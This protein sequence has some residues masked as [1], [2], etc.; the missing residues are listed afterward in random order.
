MDLYV[1]NPDADLAL[2]DGGANYLPPA[3]VRQMARDLAL[4]PAWYASPGSAVLAPSAYNDVFL[5]QM[6]AH[7]GLD[8]RLLTEPE[9]SE[10]AVERV[11]PWGWNAAVCRRLH[12]AGVPVDVLPGAD[13]L[14]RWRMLASRRRVGEWLEAF[15]ELPFCVG[16]SR[17]LYTLD[18][19]RAYAEGGGE[20]VLKMPWSGS[21]RGLLWCRDGFAPGAEGWCR[22]VLRAQGCVVASPVYDKVLDFAL[23]FRLDGRGGVAFLGY[24]C[25]ETT[26]RGAYAGSLLLP[27][28]ALE[29]W[30]AGA[31]PREWLHRV[32]A[33]ACG[34]LARE[35]AGYAGCVGID[36]MVCRTAGGGCAVHP[37][38]EVN[39]RMNMGVLAGCLARRLL[40]P[41]SWGRFV[42][43]GFPSA[44]VLRACHERD[45][46]EAPLLWV[47][48]R[49]RSGYMPLAPVSPS[50]CFRA[51]VR[52][53]SLDTADFRF[54]S[55]RWPSRQSV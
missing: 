50:S 26:A 41:G 4:L 42:V 44:G 54:H 37:C 53:Q 18:E 32:R 17:N 16:E 8:V 35:L 11:V 51:F 34:L 47:G 48:G 10:A 5:E 49:L 33:V 30:L 52:V 36:M 19:C 23:E 22:R 6:S 24:S 31:V 39:L 2:A 3:S 21:G 28:E 7:W 9:L 27:G 43:E 15:R 40:A 1:F 12:R 46:A 45:A 55:G 29:D 38:V 14:E 20:V 13:R 25:F